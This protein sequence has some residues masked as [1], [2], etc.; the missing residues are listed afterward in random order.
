MWSGESTRDLNQDKEISIVFG[1]ENQ[2]RP[3]SVSLYNG[4]DLDP[5]ILKVS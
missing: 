3:N 1:L 2:G 5:R 4:Y